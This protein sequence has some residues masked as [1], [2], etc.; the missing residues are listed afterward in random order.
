MGGVRALLQ[1]LQPRADL[2]AGSGA[3]RV[4][5]VV[6]LFGVG[7]GGQLLD[8]DLHEV[9]VAHVLAAIGVGL[10]HGL[11]H[12]VQRGRGAAAQSPHVGVLHDVQDLGH[13][14]PS[15]GGWTHGDDLV[16]AVVRRA[17]LAP[18]DLVLLQVLLRDQAAVGLHVRHDEVRRLPLIEALWPLGGNA[19]QRRCQVR[20]LEE[21]SRL[22]GRPVPVQEIA[23]GVGELPELVRKVGHALRL[24]FGELITLFGHLDGGGDQLVQLHRPETFQHGAHASHRSGDAHGLVGAGALLRDHVSVLVQVHVP[25]GCAGSHLTEVE[26][27]VPAICRVDDGEAATADVPRLG[28]EDR[29]RVPHGNG[30]VDGV[31]APVQNVLTGLVRQGLGRDGHAVSVAGQELIFRRGQR[32]RHASG[33]EQRR[34]C[35]GEPPAA[36]N[37][38]FTQPPCGRL[39]AMFLMSAARGLRRGSHNQQNFQ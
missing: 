26:G 19:L 16:A 15:A 24:A 28:V 13:D 12:D 1:G 32:A 2:A 20:L 23:L 7:L 11:G 34:Q 30:G 6:D 31:A 17:G 33:Q 39:P 9:R 21:L 37:L 36:Q 25:C 18:L 3:L 38:H 35:N 4:D 22:V 5:P 14:G 10:A 29:Q 27:V 8:G